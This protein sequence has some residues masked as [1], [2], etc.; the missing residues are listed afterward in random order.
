MAPIVPIDPKDPQPEQIAEVCRVLDRGGVVAM[1][2][3]TVYGLA[4]NPY[5]LA[6]V[7]RVYTIKG[8]SR[9]K[10]LSLLVGGMAQAIELARDVPEVF[11]DLA[12]RFWPGPLTLILEASGRLPRK[13][14]ANTGHVAMRHPRAPIPVAVS[15]KAGYPLIGT[16][17]NL[18]GRPECLNAQEAE[19]QLGDRLD[20]I[21][22][23][24]PAASPLPSTI[25]DLTTNPPQLVREGVIPAS[26]L[27]PFLE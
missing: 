11:Y 21:V 22:D 18:S 17:A 13:V 5:L 20:A 14:T 8:R 25:L 12:E 9:V 23:G 16:S 26:L 27:E 2:T 15:L 1:P 4:A 19:L 6:A 7:D 24:G 3:D 10:A